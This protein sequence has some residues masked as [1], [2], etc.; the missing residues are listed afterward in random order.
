M[1]VR[2]TILSSILQLTKIFANKRSSIEIVTM[3]VWCQDG[4]STWIVLKPHLRKTR[5]PTNFKLVTMW[6]LLSICTN[7]K[8]L[9]IFEKIQAQQSFSKQILCSSMQYDGRPLT[10]KKIWRFLLEGPKFHLFPSLFLYFSTRARKITIGSHVIAYYAN[11]SKC[12]S[13]VR[14]NVHV[15][16]VGVR[17]VY[18]TSDERT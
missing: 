14:T 11:H 17:Q 15:P 7:G 2:D 18:V 9:Y 6:E 16:F 1:H 10:V 13:I 12:S 4:S 5:G 3:Y 8:N